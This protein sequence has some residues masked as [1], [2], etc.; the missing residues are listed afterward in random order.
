MLG[1]IL[2]RKLPDLSP[3]ELGACWEETE[4]V[5]E[6][7]GNLEERYWNLVEVE[8]SGG[9]TSL[10][11]LAAKPARFEGRCSVS[12]LTVPHSVHQLDMS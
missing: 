3:I 11:S 10:S 9:R 12:T 5:Q 2:G 8:M 6:S 7:H 1:Q 4:A